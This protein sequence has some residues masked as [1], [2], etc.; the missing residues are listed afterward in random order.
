MSSKK[1]EVVTTNSVV[2]DTSITTEKSQQETLLNLNIDDL[3]KV[4]DSNIIPQKR[5]FSF[6]HSKKIPEIPTYNTNSNNDQSDERPIYPLYHVNWIS[7]IFFLW[8]IPLIKIGYKRTLQPNDLFKLDDR[9]SI[10]S[11]YNDFENNWNRILKIHNGKIPKFALVITLLRTFRYMFGSSILISIIYSCGQALTPLLTKKLINFV[12]EKQFIPHLHVNNGVGYAIGTS[13][14]MLTTGLLF[15]HF[16]HN[17]I[18]TGY[19]VRSVL[20]RAVFTKTFKI[21]QYSHH[22]YSNG[23]ITSIMSTDLSR[24]ELAWAFQPLLWSFPGPLI[25]CIVLLIINLGAISLIGFGT[26]FVIVVLILF[27]FNQIIQLRVKTNKFTDQRVSLMREILNSLKMIK[28]YAWEDAYDKNVKDIRKN[29]VSLVVKMQNIRNIFTAFAIVLPSLSSLIVFLALYKING[30]GFQGKNTGQI[31][32]SL[33]LFEVLSL[34][35]IFV[36]IALGT[37]IDGLIA[38]SRVQDFLLAEEEEKLKPLPPC[39]LSKDN[40]LELENCSFEWQDYEALIQK[41]EEDEEKQKKSKSIKFSFVK[42][43]NTTSEKQQD[44]IS[45]DKNNKKKITTNNNVA[46]PIKGFH[47][48]SFEVKRGELII[49]T[50][51][52]GTGKSSLLLA[53]ARFMTRTSDESTSTFKQTGTL[54]LCGYPWV[55]NTTVRNNILFGSKFDPIKYDKVIKACSLTTDLSNL[56][57]GDFTEIGERGVTLSGGQKARINLAR[58]VYRDKDIYLFDDVLSAVDARVGKHIMDECI[59]KFLNGKTRILATHQL[60]LIEKA[61]RVIYLGAGGSF[62]IGTVDELLSTNNGFSQLMDFSKRE[63]DKEHIKTQEDEAMEIQSVSS[64]S[65]TSDIEEKYR[66]QDTK[67]MAKMGQTILK[68]ER[69]INSMS[70]NIYKKYLKAGSGKWYL[71]ATIMY[72]LFVAFSTFTELFSSVWLSFWTEEKFK[73]RKDGFYMGLYILWVFSSL[74]FLVLQFVLICEVALRASRNLNIKAVETVLHTPMS[75]ID[76][77]PIGRILNRFTKDTEVLD[78]EI[79]EQLRMTIN[80]AFMVIGV[81]I[82]C[83]IYLPWFAIAVPFIMLSFVF[84]SDHYQ[85]SGREIKRLEAVQRSFVYNNFN[86]VLT[87]IDTV[88]AY[89]LQEMFLKKNDY[90]INKQNEA[91]YLTVATQRWVS[92]CMDIVAVCYALI[93]TLLCVT[94][95]FRIGASSTGVLLSYVLQFPGLLNSLLR[96][97]TQAENDMN[98]VERLVYYASDLPQ[99]APYRIMELKPDNNWPINANIIFQNVSLKYRPELPFVL[100]DL[101]IDIKGGEKIGVCGRTGAGKSTIMSA[102]YRLVE[103]THGKIIIDGID[104][105]KIGLFDLRSKLTIIPQD[106]VLFKGT[107]RKNLDPF[108]EC[109]DDILWNALVRS[110][111][112]TEDII[113][114]VRSQTKSKEDGNTELHKFHLDQTVEDEGSNF[115]LG[116]R[117]ILALSRALVRKSKILILDEATSSVDYETDANIQARIVKEFPHC[118]ILCIAHRL[119]TILNY[120][121]I[122]VLEKGE[123]QEFDSPIN[124]FD[125]EKGIFREMCDRSGIQRNDIKCSYGE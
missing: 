29:E 70:L 33:S 102:L 31:F 37:G 88:K 118:T 57:A 50:G 60:S 104:I 48:I 67:M 119:K 101:S 82:M 114:D 11:L 12:E 42:K 73:G 87:G 46:N 8:I 66:S 39:D 112:I 98:S 91:T 113:K 34:Q 77:T 13:V 10:E 58:S 71:L 62:N 84:I 89:S 22:K 27:A 18:M 51:G 43:K 64:S 93:I 97:I 30:N 6:L 3:E 23:K 125:K 75:F 123:I 105:N 120:D 2:V 9:L 92:I 49:V 85:S 36:P 90:L 17:S 5:L 65:S 28:Y 61:D 54:L 63:A 47:D 108:G 94:R 68:E 56:P 121:R 7:R 115:S 41:E 106:P 95:Q 35:M 80:E 26:F 78:S 86:E 76:T 44:C 55:Q 79:L 103:L 124:L 53:L 81:M 38:L 40:V 116:E 32:S 74:L 96:S 16:F 99:E 110:G 20:T 4:T 117:Q 122:L 45:E 21:S 109:N 111:A 59:I 83:I 15:N 69:A 14:L 25:I 1:P 107:I 19:Q 52:I 72:L 24:M 100:K